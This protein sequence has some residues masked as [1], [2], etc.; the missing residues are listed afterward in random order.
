M[1]GVWNGMGLSPVTQPSTRRADTALMD[2]P[3]A[4]ALHYAF[5]QKIYEGKCGFFSGMFVQREVDKENNLYHLFI[6]M[7]GH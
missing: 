5:F 4:Q 2:A 3:V 6:F 7:D 1:Y